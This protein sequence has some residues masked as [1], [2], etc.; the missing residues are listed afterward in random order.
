MSRRTNIQVPPVNYATLIPSKGRPEQL[1]QIFKKVPI[2]NTRSTYVSIEIEEE[3]LYGSLIDWSE[4]KFTPVWI[5]N[6]KGCVGDARE[7]L[8]LTALS[9]GNYDA[10][11][12]TDDNAVFTQGSFIRL[13]AAYYLENGKSTCVVSSLGQ[14]FGWYHKNLQ[15]V[16]NWVWD[17]VALL[18]FRNFTTV[19]WIIPHSL[20]SE[21]TYPEDCYIDDIFFMMWAMLK[22][23]FYNFRTVR[24]ASFSKKRFESG[25]S[26]DM[27]ERLLKNLK[28]V[29][30]LA[31][32]FPQI[33]TTKWIRLNI[34]WKDILEYIEGEQNGT[35]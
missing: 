6:T 21:F 18:T 27:R 22:K 3:D 9:E 7:T 29:E 4:V 23:G 30:T 28:G 2:L 5:K 25:G 1:M 35:A 26:G 13:L 14:P 11:F 8:R 32:H 33:A 31:N 19:N 34:N 15:D 12:S 10:Y 24:Q 16:S 20:Y 17:D